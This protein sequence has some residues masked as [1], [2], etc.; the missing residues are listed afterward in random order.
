MERI[1]KFYCRW[2]R[3]RRGIVMLQKDF[4][5]G[6]AWDA[7]FFS[8]S[9]ICFPKYSRTSIARTSMARLPW[10]IRTHFWVP[11]KFFHLLKK[12]NRLG[13]FLI[14]SRNCMYSLESP[15][16]GDSNEYTQH[17]IIVMEI[18]KFP[19]LSLFAFWPGT[20]INPQCLELPMSRIIFMVP[21]GFEPSKFDC[22]SE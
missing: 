11:T 8:F 2:G 16:L 4:F 3:M 7:T 5:S 14:L 9:F 21:K 12:T 17:T 1:E 10:L 20:M 15:H 13:F 19:K 6:L 22:T 18:K